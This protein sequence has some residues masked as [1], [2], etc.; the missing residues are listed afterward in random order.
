MNVLKESWVTTRKNHRCL[1]CERIFATGV[2][3]FSQC[4][5]DG[6]DIWT[7]YTCETCEELKDFIPPEDFVWEQGFVNN[8]LNRGE[9]PESILL[10]F[11]RN[12]EEK[13]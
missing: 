1:G 12:K 13:K 5:A 10:E 11:K 6:G 8:T 4:G 9:T 7:V 2:R 3:M